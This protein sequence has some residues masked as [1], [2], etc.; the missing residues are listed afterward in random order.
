MAYNINFQALALWIGVAA[1]VGGGYFVVSSDSSQQSSF[2]IGIEEDTAPGELTRLSVES[3]GEPVQGANISIDGEYIGTTNS[4]G[5]KGFET[6]EDNFTVEASKGDVSSETTFTVED[7]SFSSPEEDSGDSSDDSDNSDGSDDESGGSS[8]DGEDSGDG[9]SD[10]SEDS[11]DNQDSS[12]DQQDSS[13]DTSDTVDDFTGLE[14]DEDPMIGELRTLTVYEDGEKV[15]GAE[16]T[17]NGEVIGTTNAGGTVTFGVPNAAEITVSTDTGLSETFTVEDYTEEEQNQTDDQNDTED[18]TTGIQ[19]D[20]DPVSGT[21][22]R[23]I[24]Y[25][26]GDRI[27]GETVYLDGEELGQ[28]GSNGAIEF[29]VPLQEQITISTD[30]GLESQ[31]FNVT[32][33]HPEPDTILLSPDD[34]A[35]FDTVQG[36][37]TDVTFEASIEITEN[38]GTA[39]IMIDGSEAYT[40]ELSQGENTVT[41]TQALSGGSHSWS[42]EVDTEEFNVSS[43]QRGLTVNEQDVENGLTLSRDPVAE[44]SVTVQLYQENE[45]VEGESIL[46]NGESYGQTDSSGQLVIEVPNSQEITVTTENNID[47]ITRTVE[48]YTE[49]E[50]QISIN[51]P[52]EGETV[53]NYE[54]EFDFSV[55]AP[56]EGF[57][58]A[59]ILNGEKRYSE[60][61]SGDSSGV[62]E[63]LIIGDS[64]SH[65]WKVEVTQNGETYQSN[66][67]SFETTEDIP[68][69]EISFSSP[70]QNTID[71]FEVDVGLSWSTNLAHDATL[72]LDNE[73]IYYQSHDGV[74][75]TFNSTEYLE[76]GSH[77]LK[78]NLSLQNISKNYIQTLN[79]ETTEELPFATASLVAPPGDTGTG[80]FVY[81][82][83]SYTESITYDVVLKNLDASNSTVIRQ[84]SL[85]TEEGGTFYSQY[86]PELQTGTNYEWYVEVNSSE[87]DKSFQTTPNEF[88]K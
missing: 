42:L 27:S 60:S 70:A 13:E 18:L 35:T 37:T 31:T 87:S 82:I 4:Q 17:V 77:S 59:L 68:E 12:D 20:S 63:N 45:A 80:D 40:Q 64:G 39:S 71:D 28:T 67:T 62:K 73:E 75:E 36:E 78:F 9:D 57:D 65:E 66:T 46:V 25:D 55:S 15:S 86:G 76:S 41:T 38:T 43:S 72:M 44:E 61:I 81:S 88:Q 33:E 84:D 29:E 26:E 8:N 85:Q 7:G 1:V 32:E 56:E 30:Y 23:I 69:P 19:L 11:T 21:T 53:N 34:S 51:S 54:H 79:F 47:E 74:Q 49:P 16:V 3:D 58:A 14:I 10:D 22:N 24:L 5:I 6:P 52:T 83:N 48:G 50:P 2:S